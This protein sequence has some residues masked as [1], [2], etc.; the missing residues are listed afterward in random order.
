MP[1]EETKKAL[2]VVRTY[3][4]PDALR[5]ESSCTAAITDRR[6]WL[7][8][9]PVPWRLLS[10]EQRFRKYEWVQ[11]SVTKTTEDARPES[12]RLKPDGVRILSE[13]LSTANV[14]KER[15]DI[16]KPMM[17]H[18]L[19]C[20]AKLAIS[21]ARRLQARSDLAPAD[22]SRRSAALDA[23]RT[24]DVKAAAPLCRSSEA[25]TGK[26]PVQ[27]LLRVSLCGIFMQRAHDD[28]HGL[29]D[30]RVIPSLEIRVR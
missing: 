27:V 17:A 19:C 4:V 24:C 14:W 3:P 25:G 18:C 12:Y 30:E 20:L 28:V 22:R 9:F 11:V 21:D 16:V 6:E 26:N 15:K 5:I 1:D 8:L 10:K 7:R 13:P 2:I 29:G 23:C